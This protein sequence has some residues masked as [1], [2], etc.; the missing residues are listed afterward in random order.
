VSEAR[1]APGFFG[2]LPSHGDFVTRRLPHAVR[3]CFDSWLQGGLVQSRIDLG[4]GWL[5]TWLS[6]PLWRF[7]VGAGVCGEQAWLGVMMPSHDRVGR[8]F[9]LVLMAP[10]DGTPRL[11]DCMTLHDRWFEQLENLAL[12][13]LEQGFLLEAFDISLV[14]AGGAPRSAIPARPLAAQ[15][16]AA[17]PENRALSVVALAPGATPALAGEPMAGRSAWWTTG[18]PSVPPCLAVSG[19]M[20]A[21]ELFTAFLDGRWEAHC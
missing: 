19:G 2:K 16:P 21:A 9:P 15:V 4:E 14:A 3:L 20:P 10:G 7:V 13:A 8:C 1:Q 12:S 18:S 17:I 5:P 11:H 6:S